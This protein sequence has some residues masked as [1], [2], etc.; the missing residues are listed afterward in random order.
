MRTPNKS[1][2]LVAEAL[3]LGFGA[4]SAPD[5]LKENQRKSLLQAGEAF[6]YIA[7]NDTCEEITAKLS[8]TA[9]ELLTAAQAI[10]TQE[11]AQCV[12]IDWAKRFGTSRGPSRSVSVFTRTEDE[13][14]IRYDYF[15]SWNNTPE[16]LYQRSSDPT[17]IG[18][19]FSPIHPMA[20]CS[21]DQI[22][23]E[24]TFNNQRSFLGNCQEDLTEIRP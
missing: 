5:L 14:P 7:F 4:C 24:V 8:A 11:G 9:N 6:E 13:S 22:Q 16:V 10:T 23:I 1:G 17:L 3:A 20:Y 15:V 12:D 19:V 2:L 21:G 18:G